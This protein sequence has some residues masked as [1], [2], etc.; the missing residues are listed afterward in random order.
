[1]HRPPRPPLAASPAAAVEGPACGGSGNPRWWPDIRRQMSCLARSP[2]AWLTLASAAG[3]VWA[4]MRLA[5]R[6]QGGIIAIA[7][8]VPLTLYATLALR[9]RATAP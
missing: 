8:C 6:G 7:L 4:A 5:G 9:G 1:M 3:H 2:L